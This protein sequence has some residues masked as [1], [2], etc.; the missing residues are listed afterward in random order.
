MRK[1]TSQSEILSKK[2]VK[3]KVSEDHGAVT[4]IYKNT[5]KDRMKEMPK[6]TRDLMMQLTC[7]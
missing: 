1:S 5:V 7:V 3:M 6:S 2:L 4:L